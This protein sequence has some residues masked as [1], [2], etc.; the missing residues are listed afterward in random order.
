MEVT[1]KKSVLNGEIT[2]PASKSH[3]IRAVIIGALANGKS[4]LHEPLNSLDTKSAVAAVRAFGAEVDTERDTWTI[5]GVD[6]EPRIPSDVINVGNSGT[7]L[8]MIMGTA[9]LVDGW[10]VLTGDEQI[11]R[12]TASPLVEALRDLGVE[13]FSTRGNGMA[14]I[15]VKGKMRGG[16]T[17]IAGISSQYVSSLLMSCPLAGGDSEITIT[18][19][20]ERPYV[21]MT[22]DWL[23]SQ[24]IDF[25]IDDNM[26]R[27]TINGKQKYHSFSREIPG[28][29]SSATF[30]LCAAALAGG[31]VT[32]KGLE[33]NDSQGDKKVIDIL[34]EMGTT[35]EKGEREITVK[36][37]LLKGV[38]V[39]M[40]EIP[41]ALPMLA[42]TA[43]FAEGKTILHNVA[44]ARIKETDRIAVMA[45]ELKKLG[46]NIKE[47]PDGLEITGT[48]L[49]GGSVHG[50]G[51]HRVVMAMTVAG[52]A[53]EGKITVDTAESADITFP[54]FLEKMRSLG[55]DIKVNKLNSEF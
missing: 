11:R 13:I 1:S 54:G 39:D 51:D 15:A 7:T 35:V 29:F 48:G 12:R 23:D 50:Y 19:L 52:L 44:Q 5:K 45:G 8:Y 49:K 37:G 41:D 16:Q 18:E 20:N 14:P 17:S 24:G 43:C 27:A 28:D 21:R 55:A 22:L 38:D 34:A 3:T 40:N 33:M 31:K 4:V 42:V 46:A 26:S 9:S 53:A 2:V 36:G 25:E 6:S 47:L 10:T 32:I 30:P